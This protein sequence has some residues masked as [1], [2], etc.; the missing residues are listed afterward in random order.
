MYVTDLLLKRWDLRISM[1]VNE[2]LISSIWPGSYKF[3]VGD[4]KMFQCQQTHNQ[5]LPLYAQF[6]DHYLLRGRFKLHVPPQW[7]KMIENA[8]II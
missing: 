8:N 6:W 4:G 5:V 7:W 2:L 3:Y 1:H